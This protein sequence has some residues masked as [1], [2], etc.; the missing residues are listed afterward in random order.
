[1][2]NDIMGVDEL[3]N[4]LRRDARELTK[5]ASR[6][7]LPGRKVG[8]E[9]RFTTAE[10]HNWIDLQLPG[11][12]DDQLRALDGSGDGPL[13]RDLLPEACVAVPLQAR[14]RSSVLRALVDVAENSGL[15]YEPKD[16]LDAIN[17]REEVESTAQASGVAIPHPSRPMPGALGDS[18]IAFGRTTSGV[19]FGA[20]DRGLTDLFFLVLCQDSRT[21]LRVLARLARLILRPGFTDELRAAETPADAWRVIADAEDALPSA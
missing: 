17:V 21:H 8:G 16:I 11:Y 6:G 20:R 5:L 3:A 9:W 7:Q 14:T 4:Y 19:P 15:I 10:I 13:L 12:D 18:M 2:G 1:V